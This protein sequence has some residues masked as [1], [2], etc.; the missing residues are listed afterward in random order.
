MSVQAFHHHF[1]LVMASSPLQY[2]NRI[3]LDRAKALM[4]LHGYNAGSASRAVGYD[5][6]SLFGRE[7]KRL[8]DVM[9][10]EEAKRTRS[11][12]VVR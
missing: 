7:F 12:L 3:R 5:S 8:F 10:V 2:I 4:T 1:M 6:A 11:R 9:P